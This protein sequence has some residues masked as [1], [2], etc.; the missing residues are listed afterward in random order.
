ML[1]FNGNTI[2]QNTPG[3]EKNWS[4]PAL[5][6]TYNP[7]PGEAL[8]TRNDAMRRGVEM[9]MDVYSDLSETARLRYDF[10]KQIRP[11]RIE[12]EEFVYSVKIADT[13]QWTLTINAEGLF[14][15]DFSGQFSPKPGTVYE[16]LFSDFWFYGPLMPLPD[17]HTRKWIIAKIRNAFIQA[18]SPASY[19]YFQFFE[20]PNFLVSPLQWTDG[21]DKVSDFVSVR[22]FGIEWGRTN[23]RDGLVYLNFLSFEHFLN[24]PLPEY[25]PITPEMRSEINALINAQLASEKAGSNRPNDLEQTGELRYSVGEDYTEKL[26]IPKIADNAESKQL[27]MDSGGQIH[28]IYLDGNGDRYSATPAEEAKWREE[29]LRK[30]NSLKS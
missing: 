20:Y 12:A 16:Q 15:K 26:T 4:I 25:V 21:D 1:Q 6:E 9:A 2:Q 18:G 11:E 29:L 8:S 23:W 19:Q 5:F 27:F 30:Q 7:L 22:D 24:V 10:W 13:Y 28:Y 3:F 17:L 14:Y